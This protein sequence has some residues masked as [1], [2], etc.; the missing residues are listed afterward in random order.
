M[1]NKKKGFGIIEGAIFF[2]LVAFTAGVIQGSIKSYN[3]PMNQ[4]NS[5][6]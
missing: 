4:V 5:C 6:C 3:S 1:K 2:A